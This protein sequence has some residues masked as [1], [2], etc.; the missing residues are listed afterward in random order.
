MAAK[1]HMSIA[2]LYET[3]APDLEKAMANYERA[4]DYY[5]GEESKRSR[6]KFFYI[7]FD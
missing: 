1:H 7:F 5:K 2:E 4:A 6:F 3:E